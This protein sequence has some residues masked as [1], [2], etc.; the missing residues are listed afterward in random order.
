MYPLITKRLIFFTGFS[1]FVIL[2]ILGVFILLGGCQSSEEPT[3][4]EGLPEEIDFNLHVRGILSETCFAC[5]GPD[6]QSRE[7]DFR[8]DTKEGA[9]AAL[10]EKE[11]KFGIVP[12]KPMESEVYLRII[13]DDPNYSMPA[14]TSNLSLSDREIAIIKQWIEQGAEYKPHWSLIPPEKPDA[15]DVETDKKDWIVNPIDAFVL[16]TLEDKGL[17]PSPEAEKEI[18][19]RRLSFDLTGLP[20]TIEELDHFLADTSA[21]AWEKEVDRLLASEAYGERMAMEWLDVARYADTHGYQSDGPND[22]WPWRDW[23]INAFNQNMPFDQFTTWQLAGDLLP[24][25]TP[26]QKL[27]TGFG[28]LH[29]QNQE[30]GIVDEEYRIEYVA[31]RVQTTGTAFLGV[32]LQCARCHDHKYDPVSEKEYYQ[33]AAFFNSINDAGLIPKFDPSGPTIML[34]DEETERV[35]SY[36]NNQIKNKEHELEKLKAN[37]ATDFLQWF[38]NAKTSEVKALDNRGLVLHLDMNK[39]EKDSSVEVHNN[40]DSVPEKA[41]ITGQ[42][43]SVDG[44]RGDGFEFRHGNYINLRDAA[45]FERT[46]FF[47]F[48]F[49]V[50]PSGSFTEVPLLTKTGSALIGYRGYDIALLENKVSIKITHGWPFNAI[51]VLTQDSLI[52][53]QWSHVAIT[54]DGSS[55]ADGTAI[56]INGRKQKLHVEHDKLFKNIMISKDHV[57]KRQNF[58]VGYRDAESDLRYEGRL[59]MDEIRVYNRQLSDAD[60][61]ILAGRENDLD[62]ILTLSPKELNGEQRNILINHYLI[63]VDP[64]FKEITSALRELQVQKSGVQDTVREVMVMEERLNRRPSYIHKRGLYDQLGEEVQPG[65]P[66]SI[67]DFSEEFPRNRLG[68][69]QWILHPDNP[70]TSRVIVNR[71]WQMIFGQG[72]VNTPGDFGNQ[73]ALPTH[74]ELLDWISVHF[75]ENGWNV[76]ALIKQIVMSNTY[77][78]SS[79]ITPELAE[80]DPQNRLLARGPR[81][82]LPAEMIRDNAL[83]A[84]GLFVNKIGGPS[85]FPYQPEG[86]WEETTSG[87]H[88]TKYIPDTGDNLYRRS[89]YTFWKRTSP[90][91]AMTTFDA[92]M[93]IHA[94]VERTE[95]STPLQALNTMNDPIYIEAS[96]HLAE[97][98]MKEGGESL[99][100]QIAFAFRAATSRIPDD[101]EVDQLSDLYNE[102]LALYQA[103]SENAQLLLSVGDSPTSPDLDSTEVAA[104]TIVAS[105]IFN[106]DET[107]TKK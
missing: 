42:L 36:L 17:A 65:V 75:R 35:I 106:L 85:V 79:V 40:D 46:D 14:P 91:P 2:V 33:F 21:D 82:R 64:D 31:D 54:Y 73:G 3:R 107:I 5:H 1:R 47:S 19:L 22:M 8:L 59:K 99:E 98:M 39:V 51:Q 38:E 55:K 100:D 7:A 96:R 89:V 95:T 43:V 52:S 94:T 50:N 25:A 15:P 16:A 37:K 18:L 84:S 93:K 104:R 28:R 26:E 81:Y 6:A 102:E 12:G 78:Q 97:R 83:V 77:R 74:P 101:E 20:P 103:D 90:P 61:M 62:Q 30:G 41:E 66:V 11:E 10:D 49:W 80:T 9:Y 71:Y 92:A 44:V 86:L 57:Y 24:N 56:Y 13:S 70:L 29:Q 76:K 32:T 48:S 88:L 69:A 27:A 53:N 67:M 45:S 87:Q 63:Q 23:V 68:L 4:V 105:V 60:V 72:L 34:P 58:Y